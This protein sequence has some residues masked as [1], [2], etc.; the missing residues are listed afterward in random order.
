MVSANFDQ[1]P[2]PKTVLNMD[3]WGEI[4]RDCSDANSGVKL[5][6]PRS[7]SNNCVPHAVSGVNWHLGHGSQ[8]GKSVFGLLN[9]LGVFNSVV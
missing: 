2:W 7:G 6:P 5:G 4:G 8:N 1:Q 3:I 9:V